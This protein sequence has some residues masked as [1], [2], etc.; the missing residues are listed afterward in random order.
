MPCAYASTTSAPCSRVQSEINKLKKV[1][2][3]VKGKQTEAENTKNELSTLQSQLEHLERSVK[4]ADE[5]CAETKQTKYVKEEAASR[6]VQ[7]LRAEF[8]SLHEDIVRARE[9]R[10]GA[11]VRKASM[12]AEVGAV[13]QV[14]CP[15]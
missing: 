7:A 10:A 3:E 14:C 6:A 9:E 4:R 1:A 2:R 5:K 15:L 13:E 12:E 11:E 8:T